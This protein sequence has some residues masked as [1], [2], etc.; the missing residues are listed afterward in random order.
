LGDSGI[1][2]VV[3][4]LGGDHE[5]PKKPEATEENDPRSIN[6]DPNVITHDSPDKPVRV[7]VL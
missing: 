1:R 6:L 3:L 2:E 7:P 4:E 5:E